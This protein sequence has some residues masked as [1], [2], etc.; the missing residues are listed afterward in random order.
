MT[1]DREPTNT[2]KVFWQQV[3]NHYQS[4]LDKFNRWL[5][6]TSNIG[7]LITSEI[8]AIE[9]LL[10]NDKLPLYS[11]IPAEEFI[12]VS[13]NLYYKR[14]HIEVIREAYNFYVLKNNNP[15]EY[16]NTEDILSLIKNR[17]QIISNKKYDI[18][19]IRF[20]INLKCF[21]IAMGRY[22]D[23]LNELN[24]NELES[25][26]E[27]Q[28][29]IPLIE[30]DYKPEI[31]QKVIK[32]IY[33]RIQVKLISVDYKQFERHFMKNDYPI[34]KIDWHGTESQ[35]AE[36]FSKLKLKDKRKYI[37]IS[38]H[39]YDKRNQKIYDPKQLSVA[40]QK[41]SP[42]PIIDDLIGEIISKFS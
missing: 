15:I 42:V 10:F 7:Y 25:K 9:K 2:S 29:E 39:F 26:I 12:K 21:A 37:L 13:E 4:Q 24:P 35:I 40:Y 5:S 3:N 17:D 31:L 33:S 20:N 1:A 8:T 22:L 14:S 36:L 28:K 18:E 11:E 32:L 41:K 30:L 19:D 6:K 16:L 27:N 38:K 23:Y 34:E